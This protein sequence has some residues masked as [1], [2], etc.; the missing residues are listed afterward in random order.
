[1]TRSTAALTFLVEPLTIRRMLHHKHTDETISI[2][3]NP[4]KNACPSLKE[5][6][7]L[8]RD[9][10]IEAVLQSYRE[11]NHIILKRLYKDFEALGTTP[12]Q[13]RALAVLKEHPQIGVLELAEKLYLGS[14]TTSGIVDRLVKSGLV[15]SQ[16]LSSDR[17]NKAL[18]LSEEGEKIQLQTSELIR[19]QLSVLREIPEQELA[20]LRNIQQ[21]IID[22]LKQQ[23]STF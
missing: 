11:I 8:S 3:M 16:R 10:Q 18:S 13:A 2:K 17:R 5:V 12:M 1:M 23:E 7:T 22:K 9:L 19:L 6:T 4:Y 21:K 20:D 15:K 14:S